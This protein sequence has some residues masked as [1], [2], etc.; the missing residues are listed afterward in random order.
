M[1]IQPMIEMDRKYCVRR[2]PK[3]VREAMETIGPQLTLGGGFIRSC[4]AREEISDIDLFVDSVETRDLAVKLMY[5]KDKDRIFSTQNAVTIAGGSISIQIIHRWLYTDPKDIL[6]DFDFSICCAV[7]W[8]QEKSWRGLTCDSYY[9]DL[10]AKRLVY[11]YPK[12]EEDAGG[13]ALRVL[14][15]YRKGYTITLDSYGGVITRLLSAVDTE[16]A[17]TPEKMRKAVTG[18]LVE[19]D[20]NAIV[21]NEIVQDNHEEAT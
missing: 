15:Y 2:L 10:A 16:R 3:R 19:V 4:I 20:P 1:E 17:G 7:I 6:K 21:G 14:K 13:S 12:R 11:L 8:H 18:L 5:N 9:Q